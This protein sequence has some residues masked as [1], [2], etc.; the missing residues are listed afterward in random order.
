[1]PVREVAWVWSVIIEGM[2]EM[3]LVEGVSVRGGALASAV[4][5]KQVKIYNLI[6]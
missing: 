1:M 2:D 3:S 5:E 6:H 4:D